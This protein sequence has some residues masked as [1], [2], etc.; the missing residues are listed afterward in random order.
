MTNKEKHGVSFEQ[1]REVFF[2]PFQSSIHDERFSSFEEKWI[3]VGTTHEQYILVVAHLYFDD[4]G[5]E[6]I[7]IISARNA[8]NH[9]RRQYEYERRL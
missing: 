2:D 1:A 8:T 9:E 4:D 3:A 6:I 5:D 7:R